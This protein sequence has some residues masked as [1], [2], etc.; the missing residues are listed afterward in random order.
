[1]ASPFLPRKKLF[2]TSKK[3]DLDRFV[4]QTN[5]YLPFENKLC[6][7][8]HTTISPR[9]SH[10]P[11][12]SH[13]VCQEKNSA[14]CVERYFI[15]KRKIYHEGETSEQDKC[16][17][18]SIWNIRAYFFAYSLL[19][20]KLF[21]EGWEGKSVTREQ[22]CKLIH[23]NLLSPNKISQKIKKRNLAH[24]FSLLWFQKRYTIC[25]SSN[26]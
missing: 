8:Y 13:K 5:L 16:G 11:I 26:K 24:A 6:A 23:I 9:R 21:K 10:N 18:C 3:R 19:R 7:Y 17:E 25:V 15:H 1:M 20:K 2:C 12:E 4:C 22:A 14:A